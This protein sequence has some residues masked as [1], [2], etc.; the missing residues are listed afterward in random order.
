MILKNLKLIS[1][2]KLDNNFLHN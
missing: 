2:Y 1:M